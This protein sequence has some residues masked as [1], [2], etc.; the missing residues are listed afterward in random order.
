MSQ[1]PIGPGQAWKF[2]KTGQ[3]FIYDDLLKSD[4][5]PTQ[6]HVGTK[7]NM[8]STTDDIAKEFGLQ[9]KQYFNFLLF[10]M[11]S[12]F[13][14]TCIAIISWAPHAAAVLPMLAGES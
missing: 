14:F 10:V 13:L 7:L 11:V 1:V 5:D 6:E 2:T 3:P 9:I 8:L 4:I 12:N